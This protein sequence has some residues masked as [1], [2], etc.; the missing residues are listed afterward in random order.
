MGDQPEEPE[1]NAG[2]NLEAN[3]NQDE[4]IPEDAAEG[5]NMA[6]AVQGG[7]LSSITLFTGTKGLEALTYAEAID[8]SLAQFGWTQAQATQ[9]AIS[10]GGN[11]VANWI[12]G[13]RAACVTYNS[14]TDVANVQRPLRPAFIF[15]FLFIL[16]QFI[17]LVEQYPL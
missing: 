16:A 6:Q 9:A 2:E 12:R 7:Q 17:L 3:N 5:H 8:G 4:H 13:D 15:Y 11:A 10:R 14:W 1:I